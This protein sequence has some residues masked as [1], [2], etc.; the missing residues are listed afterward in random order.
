MEGLLEL[1]GV[2]PK[3]AFLALQ[4]AWGKNEGIAVDVHVHR[5]SNRLKWV[6]TLKDSK[7][8]EAT[9]AA[10]QDWMP[11]E[12]WPEVNHMLVGFG[13][14]VCRPVKPLCN[15]CTL[16]QTCPASLLKPHNRRTSAK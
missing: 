11:V 5:I 15:Q 9:R 6:N 1:P 13:Q 7:G 16:G 3:M 14:T 4:T 2:G 10:L 12:L 8:P